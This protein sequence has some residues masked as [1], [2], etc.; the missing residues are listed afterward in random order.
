[1]ESVTKALRSLKLWQWVV[2]AVILA[3]AIGGVYGGYALSTGST[4]AGLEENQQ[5]VPVQYG[6]LTNDISINGSLVYPE[7]ET[8]GFGIQGTVGEVLVEEGD[9]VQEGQV[10]AQLDEATIAS[11]EKAVAQAEVN[12]RNAEDALAE[13]KTPYSELDVA[14]A[15]AAVANAQLSLQNAEEVL[16]RLLNPTEQEIAMAE[17]NVANAKLSLESIE[18][19]LDRLLQPTSEDIATAEANVANAKLSL[20]SAEDV[21]DRLLQPTSEDIAEAEANVANAKLS[22]ESIEDAL[23]RLLQPTSEDIAEAEAAVTNAK[24]SVENAQDALDA[25]KDGP[26]KDDIASAQ[27]QVDSADI[28][29]ANAQ[30]DLRLAEKEWDDNVQAVQEA[31]DIAQEDYKDV[32]VKWLGI[33]LDKE[34][35]GLGPD[36]LLESWGVDLTSLFDP[37]QRFEDFDKAGLE[38]GPPENDPATPWSDPVVYVWLNFYFGLILP[39]CENEVIPPESVCVQKDFDDAWDI[40][41]DLKDNLDAVELQASKATASARD[42]VTHA[43]DTLDAAQQALDDLQ[44]GSDALEVENK[45]SQL[46]LALATLGMAEDTLAELTDPDPLEVEAKQKQVEVARSSLAEAEENLADLITPDPEQVDAKRKQVEVERLSLAEAQDDLAELL[47]SA[48]PRDVALREADVVS[49]QV[50]LDVAQQEL[51]DATLL[52]PMTGV[53]QT[54]NIEVGDTVEVKT[55]AMVVADPSIVEVDGTVDEIDVLFMREGADATVTMDALAGQELTGTVSSVSSEAQSLQG[56]VTYPISIRVDLPDGVQLVEGLSAVA[57]VVINEEDGLLIPL[58]SVYGSYQQPMVQ[59]VNGSNAEYREVVLGS[60]DDFWTVVQQGL[61]EG[62]KVVMEVTEASSSTFS[63]RTGGMVPGIGG[64]G[65]FGGGGRSPT[66]GG[67][68]K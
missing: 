43:E 13:A 12:L 35:T 10:L 65:G 3:G 9:E 22:L 2:L 29:L 52:A 39:T 30:E 36:T 8:L 16:D 6:T 25:A 55:P 62:E 68:G 23:D 34:E 31:F 11:L 42:A 1:M 27:A 17:A 45:E 67:G 56:V 57:N 21:L 51:D 20:E 7:K 50:T 64:A 58:Q 63:F 48:D 59:I 47:E 28:A 60:S 15:E 53:V 24:L 46:E 41:Q 44:E 40:Y 61:S 49:A 32:F 14:T 33:E 37:N 54:V 26:T 18:D 5:A 66:S 4:E 38:D 19:V